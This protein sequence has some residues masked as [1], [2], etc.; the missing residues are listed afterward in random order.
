MQ[1]RAIFR[2]EFIVQKLILGKSKINDQ[3]AS[4]RGQKKQRKPKINRRK[5]ITKVESMI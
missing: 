5:K 2:E 1:Y 3:S 4:P